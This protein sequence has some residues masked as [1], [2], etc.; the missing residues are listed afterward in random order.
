MMFTQNSNSP[1]SFIVAVH[2]ESYNESMDGSFRTLNEED[3]V[4][5]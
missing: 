1:L 2:A 5:I 3:S 4:Q